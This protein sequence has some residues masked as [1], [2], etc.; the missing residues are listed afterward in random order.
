MISGYDNEKKKD[1]AQEKLNGQ[2]RQ[3]A[4]CMKGRLDAEVD[5]RRQFDR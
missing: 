5:A 2:V 1:P 3:A 4:E